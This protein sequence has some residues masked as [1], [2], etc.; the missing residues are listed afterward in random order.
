MAA[1]PWLV[2]IYFGLIFATP[3]FFANAIPVF[4]SGMG[5]IDRGRNFVDGKPI[6]GAHKTIGGLF[7]GIL[8]GGLAGLAVSSFFPDVFQMASGFTW[9]LGFVM[10]FGAIL[11]D[12]IG[13]FTKR[14]I[15]LKSGAPFPIVDQVGFVVTAF[16]LVSIFVNFPLGWWGVVPATLLIHI[17]SNFIAYGFG[18]K[19]VWY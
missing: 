6:L 3:A 4:V 14:R 1:A 15:N 5:R 2:D 10:G 18:W 7:A 11:G 19:D 9:W 8:G 17:V 16:L 13:S 12:A